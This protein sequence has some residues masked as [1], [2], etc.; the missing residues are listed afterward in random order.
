MKLNTMK[1]NNAMGRNLNKLQLTQTSF[2]G[3]SFFLNLALC[4]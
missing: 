4:Q 2:G 1:G 3:K